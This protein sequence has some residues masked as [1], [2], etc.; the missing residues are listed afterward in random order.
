[1][2]FVSLI[3]LFAFCYTAHA[4][5]KASKD[6]VAIKKSA[7]VP[8]DMGTNK[9]QADAGKSKGETFTSKTESTRPRLMPITDDNALDS[10]ALE[11]SAEKTTHLI[12]PQGV[13]YVD[14]STADVVVDKAD[15]IDNVLRMKAVKENFSEATITVITADGQYFSFL[16]T[17]NHSP[18]LLSITFNKNNAAGRQAAKEP[19]MSAKSSDIIF[20]KA[21]MSEGEM[22]QYA[23]Y[24]MKHKRTVKHLAQVA[25]DFRFSA[26]GIY[27]KDNV[28]FLKLAFDNDA[29]IDYD[30]AFVKFFIKDKEV[31]KRTPQQDIE[32]A[33]IYVFNGG[34]AG[35]KVKG[36]TKLFRVYCFEKFTIPDDKML[37]CQVYEINGGRKLEFAVANEDIIRAKVPEKL[38]PEK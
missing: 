14:V 21:G 22:S 34:S 25:Y 2:K 32:V 38:T 29:F 8:D 16:A 35:D 26:D 28:I 24:I 11:L 10:Y 30:M 36:K 17:Y 15:V 5:K 33:P 6:L 12:F 9:E 37:W 23:E 3:L 1:M 27:I 19:V 20:E 4:Q 13:R 7:P 18:R 31:V